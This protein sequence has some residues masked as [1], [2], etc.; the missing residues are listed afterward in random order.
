M[1]TFNFLSTENEQDQTYAAVGK[2]LIELAGKYPHFSIL[3]D[4]HG[5]KV[6]LFDGA[7][8]DFA[9]P[10]MLAYVLLVLQEQSAA[11]KAAKGD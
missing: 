5:G 9:S 11:I 4:G 10:S 7:E 8:M 1:I 6:H 3:V 2:A